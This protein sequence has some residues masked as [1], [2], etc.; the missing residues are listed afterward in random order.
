MADDMDAVAVV[1]VA[2]DDDDDSYK[3]DWMNDDSCSECGAVAGSNRMV[4]TIVQ[5]N[6][7]TYVCCKS[8][9]RLP[10]LHPQYL[11]IHVYTNMWFIYIFVLCTTHEY[12]PSAQISTKF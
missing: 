4:V 10:S 6:I 1:V 2:D 8:L 11:W 5:E 9:E 3:A 12:I 7:D